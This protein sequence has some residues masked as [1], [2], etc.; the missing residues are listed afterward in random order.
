MTALVMPL[1]WSWL[2][3]M[4]EKRMRGFGGCAGVGVWGF[5]TRSDFP[6]AATGKADAA[7][8]VAA[9]FFTNVRRPTRG[10]DMLAPADVGEAYQ[11]RPR[12]G[13]AV[14]ESSEPGASKPV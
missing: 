2:M 9:R 10:L 6:A 13:A 12:P 8:A 3:P 4:T 1:M 11:N 7:A 5:S 14:L